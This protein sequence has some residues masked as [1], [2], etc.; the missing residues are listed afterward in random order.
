[1]ALIGVEASTLVMVKSS[2]GLLTVR[3][4][5]RCVWSWNESVLDRVDVEYVSCSYC[6]DTMV[7]YR[8]GQ[9]H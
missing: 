7:T 4:G 5:E 3:R 6:G 1:M 9:S 2:D 8:H